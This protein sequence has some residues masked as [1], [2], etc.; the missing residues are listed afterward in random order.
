MENRSELKAIENNQK[1][2]LLKKN[3][4]QIHKCENTKIGYRKSKIHI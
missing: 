4:F 2:A 1:N 3:K